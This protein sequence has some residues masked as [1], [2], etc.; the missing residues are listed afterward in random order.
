VPGPGEPDDAGRVDELDEYALEHRLLRELEVAR[1]TV[2]RAQRLRQE[3]ATAEE[4]KT[5]RACWESAVAAFR[6][7]EEERELS[8]GADDLEE[9]PPWWR[10]EADLDSIPEPLYIQQPSDQG[11]GETAVWYELVNGPLGEGLEVHPRSAPDPFERSVFDE[12]MRRLAAPDASVRAIA[13]DTGITRPRVSKIH[14]YRS[15]PNRLGTNGQPGYA[16]YRVWPSPVP[17]A[18]RVALRKLRRSAK[19]A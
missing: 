2:H 4:R 6:A 8:W 19:T 10:I 11:A 7:N 16:L 12:V 3:P 14:V 9:P 1:R 13:E 5:V 18:E 17:L 15:H